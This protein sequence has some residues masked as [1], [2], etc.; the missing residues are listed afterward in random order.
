M[1]RERDGRQDA[2]SRTG[3]LGFFAHLR[4]KRADEYNHAWLE[5][6]PLSPD[7]PIP[8]FTARGGKTL[9]PC[10]S[11]MERGACKLGL[12]SI[13]PEF[14]LQAAGKGCPSLSLLESILKDAALYRSSRSNAKSQTLSRDVYGTY[15]VWDTLN[16]DQEIWLSPSSLALSK[17]I[18]Q[19]LRGYQKELL[20]HACASN[21]VVFLDTGAG[22]TRIA[23]ELIKQNMTQLKA[24]SQIA[25]LL[26]PS[27]PLVMQVEQ[28]MG[29]RT[30]WKSEAGPFTTSC[31]HSCHA[32]IG[33][34]HVGGHS[35]CY[36]VRRPLSGTLGPEPV[37]ARVLHPRRH[38]D[39][40]RCMRIFAHACKAE[41]GPRSAYILRPNDTWILTIHMPVAHHR[42]ADVRHRSA[43]PRRVSSCSGEPRLCRSAGGLLP[44]SATRAEAKGLG[45]DCLPQRCQSTAGSHVVLPCGAQ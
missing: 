35:H 4:R 26:A 8:G 39:D 1:C 38:R 28:N 12:R 16:L 2:Q 23:V 14:G 33:S 24:K 40:S 18:M 11:S 20:S 27:V 36:S 42:V 22:K 15:P 41:G 45:P 30:V 7:V 5:P 9:L 21:V 44:C 32:A 34:S 37:A 29:T 17:M 43:G 13:R 6:F 19:P 31:M 25:L 3:P 10:C